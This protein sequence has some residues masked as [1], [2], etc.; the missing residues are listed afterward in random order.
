[1]IDRVNDE[2]V[3]L[4]HE[5]TVGGAVDCALKSRQSGLDPASALGVLQCTNMNGY[6][7]SNL[8]VRYGTVQHSAQTCAMDAV[9][10]DTVQVIYICVCVPALPAHPRAI[11]GHSVGLSDPCD[12]VA[13]CVRLR[14]E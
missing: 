10:V 4:G 13:G 11:S 12:C 3:I 14:L 7:G 6:I 1:M 8:C 5:C 9:L 2:C